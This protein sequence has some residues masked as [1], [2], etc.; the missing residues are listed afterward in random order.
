MRNLLKASGIVTALVVLAALG[1]R[2]SARADNTLI[3]QSPSIAGLIQLHFQFPDRQNNQQNETP[4][5]L[6]TPLS[7]VLPSIFRLQNSPLLTQALWVQFAALSQNVSAQ[8]CAAITSQIGSLIHKIGT[9]G[10]NTAYNI[11]PCKPIGFVSLVATEQTKWIGPTSCTLA[12]P[13]CI[14]EQLTGPNII[15]GHRLVL[16]YFVPNNVITFY[17]TTKTTCSASAADPLCPDDPQFWLVYDTDIQL[18]ATSSDPNSLSCP[19]TVDAR[20]ILSGETLSDNKISGT[21]DS[22]AQSYIRGLNPVTIVETY[23]MALVAPSAALMLKS[24][25]DQLAARFLNPNLVDMVSATLVLANPGPVDLSSVPA[26][27]ELQ[28]FL[29]NCNSG[30]NLGFMQFEASAV[31]NAGASLDGIPG[32]DL[33]FILTHPI[34][35][36]PPTL[37]NATAV[38]ANNLFQPQL[39]GS[40]PQLHAG[41]KLTVNGMNFVSTQTKLSWTDAGAG[42]ATESDVQYHQKGSTQS[43]TTVT[44]TRTGPND[45][46]NGYSPTG[47]ISGATY[48]FQVRDCDLVTCTPYSTVLDVTTAGQSANMVTL[49]LDSV[50]PANKLAAIT[51]NAAGQFSVPV[52]IS[53]E[54]PAGDH[55][56][57]AIVGTS[58][59]AASRLT[60]SVKPPGESLNPIMQVEDPATHAAVSN[61]VQTH[62]FVLAGSGFSPGTVV[63]SFANAASALATPAV[64]TAGTF[65]ITLAAPTTLSGN[66]QLVAI[67]NGGTVAKTAEIFVELLPQ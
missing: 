7:S 42:G 34:D 27:K 66:Q 10:S 2:S 22:E 67:E 1:G 8:T 43:P 26:L 19:F 25:A 63:I 6:P 24:D 56:I 20:Q 64:T 44:L 23:G 14:A 30:D 16:D 40:A 37:T 49:Y 5:S 13:N 11:G 65:E 41:Q 15:S 48:E 52:T 61:V 31:A 58:T 60:V 47:L 4:S 9:D 50:A 53:A 54:T 45:N 3:N 12:D 55:A 21:L 39:T 38:A 62:P 57:L 18:I 51:V 59:T 46:G 35:A 36:T 33:N 29:T 17:V 28:A 32:F